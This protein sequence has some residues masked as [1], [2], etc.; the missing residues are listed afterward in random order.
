VRLILHDSR[1]AVANLKQFKSNNTKLQYATI[2]YTLTGTC[3]LNRTNRTAAQH[4]YMHIR[5]A[6]K[7]KY[8]TCPRQIQEVEKD[9]SELMWNWFILPSICFI[10]SIR[11]SDNFVWLRGITGRSMS[12]RSDSPLAPRRSLKN[13][14]C[15]SCLVVGLSAEL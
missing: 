13:D 9:H 8:C 1:S 11:A 15:S 5:V 10:G 3:T 2:Q 6:R 4:S 7:Y 14:V 12:G